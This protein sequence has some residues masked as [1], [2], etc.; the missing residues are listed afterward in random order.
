MNSK[1]NGTIIQ[2]IKPLKPIMAS[3]IL[4]V[5]LLTIC[6]F[7][8]LHAQCVASIGSN[9]NPIEESAVKLIRKRTKISFFFQA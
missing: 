5:I 9:I 1:E 7:S 6:N 3:G 4:G 2:G 8:T